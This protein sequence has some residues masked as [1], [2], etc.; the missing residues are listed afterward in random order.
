[1]DENYK[2]IEIKLPLMAEYVSV[3][4]LSASGIANIAGF[5]IEALE[6]IKVAVSE[7]CNKLVSNYKEEDKSFT[8]E[9][10]VMPKRMKIIFK[11]EVETPL[12]LFGEE[13]ELGMAIIDALMDEIDLELSENSIFSM[14]KAIEGK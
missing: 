2:I 10:I 9:F 6:D 7:V 3:A 1:M 12:K 14:S 13:D 4:R 8:I 11:Y 5:D